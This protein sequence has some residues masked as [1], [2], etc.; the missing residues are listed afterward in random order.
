MAFLETET[1]SYVMKADEQGTL[2]HL[3]YGE[4]T[5]N[6]DLSPLIFA[7]SRGHMTNPAEM[8]M[9]DRSY[10][11]DSLPQ[12]LATFDNGDTRSAGI[13]VRFS[14]GT[15]TG[16]LFFD[17]FRIEKGKYSIPGLPASYD[18]RSDA[19]T[20]TVTLK[21]VRGLRVEIRYGVFEKADVIARS[22]RVFNDSAEPFTIEKAASLQLDLCRSDYE[23]MTFRGRW[24]RECMAERRSVGH[25]TTAIG[26]KRGG[27]SLQYNPSAI[28]CKPSTTETA[29]NAIGTAFLYSGS[30]LFELEQDP[31]D[32]YR[33]I[34]G[35]HPEVF[36]WRLQPGESFDTPEAIMTFSSSGFSGI[37]HRFHDFI[38][39]SVIR[40]PWR[41]KRKPVLINNW[42]G[43][44]FDFNAEKLTAMAR[45]AAEAGVD[46]FVMD[47]GWFGKRDDDRSGLGDW[48]VNEKKLG[49]SASE[50]GE[51]IRNAGTAFGIWFEP[52]AVSPDSDLDRNHPE[53]AIAVPGRA[54]SLDRFEDLLDMGRTDVQDYLIE[55]ITEVIRET[56]AVYLKW[57]LNR[58][59]TDRYSAVLSAETQGEFDHRYILGV[60]RV[61]EAVRTAFPE[62]LIEGCSSG[63]GRFDAGMLYYTPQIWT[64]DDTD[65]IE[66]L[67]IQ[68]GASFIYPVRCMGAHVSASPNHQ[69]GRQ[70]PMY[71]RAVVAMSGTY[72][73]ELDVTKLSEE[74]KEEMR[75]DIG[76]FRKLYNTLEWGDLYRLLPPTDENA[77]VWEMASKDKKQA[78][79][80]VVFH[81]PH[82]M[83][84]LTRFYVEGLDDEK[85]YRVTLAD[86]TMTTKL[87][88]RCRTTFGGAVFYGRSLRTMG[89]FAPVS[90]IPEEY[91]AYQIVIEE[92]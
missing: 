77:T 51:R 64:S 81:A 16:R 76:I 87:D 73:Y 68:N 34:L 37:S 23:L 85:Q 61:L 5:G 18:E 26:S 58:M 49:C 9:I 14:D 44:Y 22:M 52:E 54:P 17:S 89:L 59:T 35:I 40:G 50:L 6:D 91:E 70:T 21:D 10:S 8:G 38:N 45:V 19:E 31:A 55:R 25:G 62:L 24:A 74:A 80:N 90:K 41:D 7:V 83:R 1:T 66:R 71:T 27:S 3:Y 11:F 69:S 48:F 78:V 53:W 43:T 36:S 46:L 60:Y 13:I 30:F 29:G 32:E 92:V 82:T 42:E 86:P 12:E 15:R 39:R 88:R 4:K 28:L 63:G 84:P 47:D 33:M 20:L 65:P 2:L 57:D 72:G 75:R 79:V 56:G 67:T